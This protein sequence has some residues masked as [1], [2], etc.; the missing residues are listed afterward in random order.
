MTFWKKLNK[1]LLWLA[2]FVVPWQLRHTLLFA[3]HQ[4]E[5]FEYASIS[6]YLSDIL[7]GLVLL[8]WW[9][10]PRKSALKFGPKMI[11]WP[12]MLLI[13]W[14][15]ISV[16]YTAASAGNWLVGVNN[17]AHLTLFSLL[18]WYLVNRIE[19]ITEL[20]WPLIGG[21]ILQSIVA[22][23]QY[24]ANHSLGLKWL[25]ESVLEPAATGV[26][27]VILDGERQLRA[28]GTLPH[29]NILGGYLAV[30]LPW[31]W[32]VY[33]T[34]KQP[35][36]KWLAGGSLVIG[37]GALFLSF[38]RSAWL[39]GGVAA[40]I[41]L[42]WLGCQMPKFKIHWATG[43]AI[44][45]IG[46]VIYSQWGA[47]TSRFSP[48]QVS[49]EKE[50]VMSR[51]DQWRQFKSVLADHPVFGVGVGQYT[52]Y[53]AKQDVSKVG[54]RYDSDFPGWAYN[55]SHPVWDYQPV[56]NLWLMALAEL[57]WPGLGLL[58]WLW[59]GVLWITIRVI[60]LGAGI[61]GWLALASWLA[62]SVLGMFDH[63]LWTLQQGRLILFLSISMVAVIYQAKFNNLS[64]YG[65]T[66]N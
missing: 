63:Y 50:S 43:V 42:I 25:G 56:H 24:I 15:W 39:A 14:A 26:P 51:L 11:S 29:A 23:G 21:S 1:Y 53:L 7:I 48:D 30:S 28:H 2:I 19:D 33:L 4:G 61:W 38:S 20:L 17:A 31:I 64:D 22:I 18:Y 57:G 62:I 12:L 52:L 45:A 13:L 59:L 16:G 35:I 55:L 8:T 37:A 44:L 32:M 58:I 36:I 60:K 9:L 6:V 54:W 40:V 47:I 5:F 49:L 41:L 3:D 66:T 65:R 10:I 46:L 27:V 34:N